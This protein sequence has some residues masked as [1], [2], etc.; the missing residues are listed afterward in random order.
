M[1]LL[2]RSGRVLRIDIDDVVFAPFPVEYHQRQL[3]EGW[4]LFC[5]WS[6]DGVEAPS[7]LRAGGWAHFEERVN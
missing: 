1:K 6:V 2:H 5:K 4:E 3:L 7:Y